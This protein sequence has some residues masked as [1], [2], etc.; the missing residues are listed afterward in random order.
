MNYFQDQSQLRPMRVASILTGLAL[1]LAACGGSGALADQ[2]VE[3]PEESQQ[4][5]LFNFGEPA[6]AAVADRV[7]EIDENDNLTFDA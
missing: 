4:Q 6:D 1:V 7:I 5:E 2:P 3:Q